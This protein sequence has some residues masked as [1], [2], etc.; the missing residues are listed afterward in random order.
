MDVFRQVQS[1]PLFR[2]MLILAASVALS[3]CG[4]S[5][6]TE[7]G[8]KATGKA[9]V[10]TPAQKTDPTSKPEAPVAKPEAKPEAHQQD[11]QKSEAPKP[12]AQPDVQPE[13]P[14]SPAPVPNDDSS[15]PVVPPPAPVPNDSTPRSTQP[16]PE[17][18]APVKP[19]TPAPTP[20][21]APQSANKFDLDDYHSAAM[22]SKHAGSKSWTQTAMTVIHGRIQQLDKARDIGTFCPGYVVSAQ[23]YREM[24]WLRLVTAV[25]QFESGHNPVS[26]FREPNGVMSIGLF[27]LSPNECKGA[28]TATDLKDPLRNI[29]CGLGMMTTLIV[30]DG[31]VDGP[32]GNRGASSYW[33]VL[34]MPYTSAGYNLGK[35]PAI[36]AMTQAYK[37]FKP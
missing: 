29:A 1:K 30:R 8:S 3:A 7:Y 17:L 33:S 27:A 4:G 12:D 10:Q 14:P 26:T 25:A 18:E 35:K 32:A 16:E 9:P 34:R 23:Q 15:K 36:M 31:Y 28:P 11:P 19:Q 5:F 21:P 24:C 22:W 37:Q 20:A 6:Q 2:S 13:T